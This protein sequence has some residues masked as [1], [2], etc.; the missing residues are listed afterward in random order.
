MQIRL[1]AMKDEELLLKMRLAFL[2]DFRNT[3]AESF[4]KE[5]VEATKSFVA[6]Q[7]QTETMKSWLAESSECL[8][9]APRPE[10]LRTKEGY[11]INM[12]VI[13]GARGLGIGPSPA[14][15]V[16]RVR[17]GNGRPSA[18]S[19]RHRRWNPAL[20]IRRVCNQPPMDGTPNYTRPEVVRSTR[21]GTRKKTGHRAR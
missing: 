17:H 14:H 8:G 19:S 13:P 2:A 5:F 9:V 16:S 6:Q 1:A 4:S 21:Q 12:Y 18:S 11:I 3:A 10:D 20:P 7:M 15:R